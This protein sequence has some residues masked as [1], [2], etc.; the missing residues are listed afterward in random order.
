[1]VILQMMSATDLSIRGHIAWGLGSY[2]Y[3]HLSPVP[4]RF[5]GL[6][7]CFLYPRDRHQYLG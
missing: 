3:L 2:S 4:P 5:L 6:L 1:M 7:L